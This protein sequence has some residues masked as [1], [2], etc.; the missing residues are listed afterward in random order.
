[1]HL[2]PTARIR[3]SFKLDYLKKL[4]WNIQRM[5]SDKKYQSR[6]DNQQS[7]L[8]NE[9]DDSSSG[10][11]GNGSKVVAVCREV[12]LVL[13]CCYCCF[14]CG[15]NFNIWILCLLISVE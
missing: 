15:G 14:C 11:D 5:N 8:D 7:L 3:D 1:M 13:S 12:L 6:S 4:E 2:W 9:A 10:Q